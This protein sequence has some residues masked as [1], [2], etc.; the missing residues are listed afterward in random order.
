MKTDSLWAGRERLPKP[1][2][3]PVGHDLVTACCA[4]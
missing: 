2:L 3:A 4:I 1:T